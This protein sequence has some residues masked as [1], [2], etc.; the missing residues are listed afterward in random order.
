[1]TRLAQLRLTL[2]LGATAL[3]GCMEPAPVPEWVLSCVEV[4]GGPD[5]APEDAQVTSEDTEAGPG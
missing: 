1:M 3:S 4:Q 2:A 5:C